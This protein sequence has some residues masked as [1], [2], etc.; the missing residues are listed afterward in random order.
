MLDSFGVSCLVLEISTVEVFFQMHFCGAVSTIFRAP[1][2]EKAENLSVMTLSRNHDTVTQKNPCCETFY[3][4]TAFLL[5]GAT[6]PIPKKLGK[7]CT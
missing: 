7:L 1:F 6:T 4:G 2:R 5:T 3:E